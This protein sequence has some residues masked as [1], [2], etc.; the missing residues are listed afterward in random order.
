MNEIKVSII[1]CNYNYG[2]FLNASVESALAQTYPNVEVI[3]VDD[4]STDHS[5]K[6]LEQYRGRVKLIL[7]DHEGETAGRNEGFRQSTGEII[8][9]LDSDDFLTP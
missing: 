7:K 5:R 8:T 6:V 1:I 3:V 4:G 2:E 9:F